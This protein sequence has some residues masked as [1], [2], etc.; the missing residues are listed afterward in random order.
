MRIVPRRARAHWFLTVLGFATLAGGSASL[1]A[2][3]EKAGQSA[4]EKY[5]AT[6]AQSLAGFIHDVKT[7]TTAE[8]YTATACLLVERH[9]PHIL[10]RTVEKDDPGEFES[11]RATQMQIFKSPYVVMAALRNPNVQ[12]QP[13]IK[14]E[15]DR[16]HAVAWLGKAI[17]VI[18]PDQRAGVLTVSLTSND[19][20]EAAVLVNAMVDAYMNEVVNLDRQRRRDRLSDLQQIS[21]EKEVEVRT[22]REQLKRELENIG[23]GD[24][25]TVQARIQLAMSMYA[26]FQHQFQAMRAEHRNAVARLAEAKRVLQDLATAEIPQIEVVSLLNSDPNYHRLQKRIARLELKRR[27]EME[28]LHSNEA[29]PGT[30]QARTQAEL[31]ST[32]EQLENLEQKSGDLVRGARRIALEM[33]IRRLESQIEISTGQLAA[34]EKEVERKGQDAE[35]V[36]RSSIAANMAR[37]EVDNLEQILRAVAMEREI[38]RVNL[39]AGPRVRVLGDPSAPAAVPEGPD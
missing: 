10:A 12:A 3:A 2:A 7:A 38:L 32:K 6:A 15:E 24:E 29:A 4:A 34:F 1:A 14:R 36:G 13:S 30:E 25:Q 22:K 17:R 21:A 35:S 26:E 28:K 37:A 9:E 16:H 5:R 19:R 39:K 11:Y 31:S 20:K 27:H 23:A 18:C 8:K 33:E